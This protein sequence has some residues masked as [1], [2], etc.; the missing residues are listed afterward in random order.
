MKTLL[1]IVFIVAMP[2]VSQAHDY[3]FSFVEM[4]YNAV[5]QRIEATLTVTTHDFERALEENGTPIGNMASIS[6]EEIEIIEK[7][8]NAHFTVK[9]GDQK[10]VLKFM[11][12]EVSMDGTSNW[13]FES[14]SIDF[15]EELSIRYDLLMDDFPEQQNKVTLYH[16]GQTYTA[17]F[18]PMNKTKQIYIEN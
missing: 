3:F 9:S 11:G 4:E 5:S 17:A 7:Y 18:T 15:Q 14:E 2:L 12:N 16:M 8:V 13:Y 1:L 6:K 10:S